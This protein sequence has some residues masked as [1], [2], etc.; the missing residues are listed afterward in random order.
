MTC[1]VGNEFTEGDYFL[2]DQR[3]I[4]VILKSKQVPINILV[5]F[6][7]VSRNERKTKAGG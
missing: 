3:L 2:R 6:Q 4:D 1:Q 5:L 7:E